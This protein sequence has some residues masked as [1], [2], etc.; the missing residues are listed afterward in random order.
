MSDKDDMS[1]W[2]SVPEGQFFERKSCFEQSERKIR[3]R[4]AADAARDIAETLSAMA[5]ADRVSN[6]RDKT[7]HLAEKPVCL[8]HCTCSV[9][10]SEPVTD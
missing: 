4:N 3:H 6:G 5:N 1:R 9:A 2:C 10:R 7:F 8:Y